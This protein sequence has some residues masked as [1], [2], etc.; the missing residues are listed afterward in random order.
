M[1]ITAYHCPWCGGATNPYEKV[2]R[3][4]LNKMA[5]RDR[6]SR[7]VRVLINCGE[8]YVYFDDIITVSQEIETP[9]I[10]CC[11]LSGRY[12]SFASRPEIALSFDMILTE[13]FEKLYEMVDGFKTNELRVEFPDRNK[14]IE[15]IGYPT[16]EMTRDS[17]YESVWMANMTIQLVGDIKRFNTVVP[18]GITCPNCGAEITSKYGAC[19][20]CGGWIEWA[21][22][23]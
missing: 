11:D 4:C 1:K 13:R 16:I 18:K 7:N 14:A 5:R 15:T 20:Y 6:K 19:D 21:Q 10:D 17:Y 2:C 8:D 22:R 12:Y 23:A 3:Y 9:H